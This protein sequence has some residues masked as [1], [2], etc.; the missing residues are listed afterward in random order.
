MALIQE[1]S[2]F[3]IQNAQ[4]TIVQGSQY[5]TT[6]VH[7]NRVVVRKKKKKQTIWDEYERVRIGHIYLTNVVGTSDVYDLRWWLKSGNLRV[8]ARRTVSVARI[9][10]ED[11]DIEFLY[12]GY[13]GPEALKRFKRDFDEFSAVKH[14]NVAQL[15]GYNDQRGLPAL[16]F[17]DALIPFIHVLS[18]NQ[19]LVLKI[20]FDFQIGVTRILEDDDDEPF[21]NELW[22]EP[23]SGALRRGPYVQGDVPDSDPY[24]IPNAPSASLLDPLPIQTYGYTSTIFDYLARILPTVA[25]LEGISHQYSYHSEQVTPVEAWLYLASPLWKRNQQDIIVRWTGLTEMPRYECRDCNSST[26]DKRKVAMKD[27]SIRF[28][29]TGPTNF[30]DDWWLEYELGIQVAW[31]AQ[32]YGIFSQL[33]IR[34]E[35]W[36]EYSITAGFRLYFHFTEAQINQLGNTDTT[37]NTL[38]SYLFVRRIPCPSDDETLWRSW[39]ES[40]KYFW[41]F[42]PSGREEMSESMRA[43]LRLPSFTTEIML[44]QDAWILDAYK[45]IEMINISKGFDPKT[46]DLAR[47]LGYPLLKVIG[48]EARFQEL[49]SN[50]D[51]STSEGEET[52]AVDC[53]FPCLDAASHHIISSPRPNDTATVGNERMSKAAISGSTCHK[54]HVDYDDS[55][56]ERLHTSKTFDPW[57]TDYARFL[58]Y[59]PIQVVVDED[60]PQDLEDSA[61]STTI[62]DILESYKCLDA[63]DDCISNEGSESDE[64]IVLYPRSN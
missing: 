16:I 45:A 13:S 49:D 58:G 11:G 31:L 5:N 60:R 51:C 22:I 12:M 64:E 29:F 55:E 6:H 35:E 57:T 52:I 14:P 21:A 20:Y 41:S 24:P 23:R 19:S 39:T 50:D 27:G 30:E 17:Y 1:C 4:F 25:I 3:A 63:N 56:R 15:F 54:L 38:T 43:Y 26:T 46:T 37:S 33:G 10:G 48:D 2:D 59:S 18:K 28:Q 40:A 61:S 44:W 7:N 53:D 47:S 8:V 34:E 42:D 62:A 9:R 36:N 32:A